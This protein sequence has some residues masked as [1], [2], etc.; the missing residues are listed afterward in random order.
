[1]IDM[2]QKDKLTGMLIGLARATYGND[3]I[4]TPDTYPV[5]I[6]ALAVDDSQADEMMKAVEEEKYRIVPDCA[7]CPVKCGRNEDYDLEQLD[8]LPL[9]E[10]EIKLTLLETVRRLAK[11]VKTTDS[12]TNSYLTKALMMAGT[13]GLPPQMLAEVVVQG[14][15]LTEKHCKTV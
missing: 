11:C 15:N 10:K 14:Q 4:I 3:D 7:V 13:P 6:K 12:E 2:T 9:E 8:S 1:M 5:M